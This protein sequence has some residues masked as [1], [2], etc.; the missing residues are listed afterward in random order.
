MKEGIYQYTIRKSKKTAAKA[1]VFSFFPKKI[2]QCQPQHP[3][4]ADA[5]PDR[6]VVIA[7]FDGV[8]GL[9]GDAHGGGQGILAQALLFP[10]LLHGEILTHRPPPSRR[11]GSEAPL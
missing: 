4:D 1:A 2:V 5:E 7:L 9:P 11:D 3:A 6:G 10:G 8:D